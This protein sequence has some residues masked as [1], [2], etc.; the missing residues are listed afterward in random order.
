MEFLPWWLNSWH[1]LNNRF[2]WR[3]NRIKVVMCMRRLYCLCWQHIRVLLLRL[4]SGRTGICNTLDISLISYHSYR[5]E[6]VHLYGLTRI[7]RCRKNP[8]I[9]H[10]DCAKRHWCRRCRSLIRI[11]GGQLKLPIRDGYIPTPTLPIASWECSMIGIESPK[12][13]V[14]D[15]FL[16]VI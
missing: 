10:M 12:D 8:R 4:R 5:K 15:G 7:T 2:I 6:H 1:S 14:T 3:E 11:G 16:S 13:A 9:F